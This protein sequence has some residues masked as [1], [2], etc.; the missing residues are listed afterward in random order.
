MS[1]GVAPWFYPRRFI[2]L[3]DIVN[4]PQTVFATGA[5]VR[6][7]HAVLTNGSSGGAAVSFTLRADDGSPD[8]VTVNVPINTTIVIPGWQVDTEGLE[9]LTATAA[10][11]G[12]HATF[13]YS[14]GPLGAGN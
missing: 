6:F 4:S 1:Q 14:V 2:R 11:T 7:S 8:V 13:F 12:V 3:A 9:I 5:K 10:V